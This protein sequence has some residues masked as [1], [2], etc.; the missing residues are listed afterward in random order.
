MLSC[1]FPFYEHSFVQSLINFWCKDRLSYTVLRYHIYNYLDCRY[2]KCIVENVSKSTLENKK[3]MFHQIK[4]I[5]EHLADNKEI[6]FIDELG[7]NRPYKIP[8]TWNFNGKKR[9]QKI[10]IPRAE[11]K[12]I[13]LSH[14]IV[15]L[16][17][18]LHS[19]FGF[20]LLGKAFPTYL[21]IIPKTYENRP[22]HIWTA[23]PTY[24]KIITKNNEKHSKHIER[25]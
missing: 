12:S 11:N 8:K 22:K 25:H 24:L 10:E 13:I 19:F 2:Q 20:E 9:I 4:L 5:T 18:D 3:R 7:T 6:V 23:S 1:Y 17:Y 16:A 15:V 21:K 14:K